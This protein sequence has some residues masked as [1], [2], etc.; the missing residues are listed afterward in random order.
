MKKIKALVTT[1]AAVALLSAMP[2]TNT[3]KAEAAEPKNY[4]VNFCS[5]YGEGEWRYQEGSTF[6]EEKTHREIYYLQ[7][8]L[9]AGD[10]VAVYN[11]ASNASALNL[12]NVKLGDLTICHTAMTVVY[13]GGISECHILA[14]SVC[15]INGEIDNAHVYDAATVTFTGNVNELIATAENDAFNSNIGCNGKVWHLNAYSINAPRT[16]YNLYNFET[17]KLVIEDGSLKTAANYYSNTEPARPAQEQAPAAAA[18]PAPSAGNS[19]AYD[20]VPKTGE[21]NLILWFLAASAFCL[22]GSMMLN[23]K[24]K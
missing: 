23:R 22:T 10:K 3:L 9:K 13:T 19:G 18:T 7:Q 21:N 6:D 5:D 20:D 17:N 16:F 12:G 14:G 4:A 8:D 11:E 2:Q 24:T 15:S 1:L